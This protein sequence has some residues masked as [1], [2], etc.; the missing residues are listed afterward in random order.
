VTTDA[1]TRCEW[2]EWDSAFFGVRIARLTG[3][4]DSPQAVLQLQQW[5]VANQPDCVYYLAGAGAA[6]SIRAAEDL[7]FR[8]MDARVT[9]EREITESAPRGDRFRRMYGRIATRI[10]R[11]CVHWPGLVIGTRVFTRTRGFRAG[12]ATLYTKRG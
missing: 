7:G 9:L 12:N 3:P 1:S 4:L 10:C 2:L 6:D 11:R 8:Y 5:L